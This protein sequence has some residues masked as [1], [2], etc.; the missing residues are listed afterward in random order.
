MTHTDPVLIDVP[1]PIRTP[2]LYLSPPQAGDG[3]AMARAL[4]ETWDQLAETMPWA[5]D[6]EHETNPQVKEAFARHK[7]AE[8]IKR[9]DIMLMGFP[10][11]SNTAIAFCGLHRFCWQRRSFEVGYW[12]HKD[13]QGNGY[14]TETAN[15]LTRYAFQALGARKVLITHDEGNE[16][17]KAVIQKLGFEKEGINKLGTLLPNGRQVDNHIYALTE[18]SPLPDI[19]VNWG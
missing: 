7:Q 15:A 10:H 14:A 17:S 1:M 4:E 18:P 11:A 19:D 12:I 16:A 9:E 5:T 8:F 3:P 13:W 2:R 6:H